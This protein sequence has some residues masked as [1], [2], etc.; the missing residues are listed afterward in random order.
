[1]IWLP[2]TLFHVVAVW[3]L[4]TKWPRR[5]DLLALSWGAMI[6]DLEHVTDRAFD[7]GTAGGIMHSFLG[8][9]TVNLV[10]TLFAARVLTPAVAVRLDRRFPGK[11]WRR[12]AGHDFLADRKGWP[13]AIASGLLGGFSHVALDLFSHKNVPL[14]WPWR[15]ANFALGPWAAEWWAN[16]AASVLTGILFV[17]MLFRWFRR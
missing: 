3:P 5:W 9:A 16:E 8:I 10:L 2:F 4:Y 6:P 7:V 12:F 1:V 14:L 13:V 17:W 15:G 11:G